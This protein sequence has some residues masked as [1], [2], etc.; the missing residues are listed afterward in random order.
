MPYLKGKCPPH[1]L[2][3]PLEEEE[4]DILYYLNYLLFKDI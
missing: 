3:P 1:N 2:P 4:E